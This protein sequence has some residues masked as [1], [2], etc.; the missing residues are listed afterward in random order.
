MTFK[1]SWDVN[2]VRDRIDVKMA[3]ER[4]KKEVRKRTKELVKR[5]LNDKHLMQ[6]VN[7]RV[8]PV[9]DYVMNVCKIGKRRFG[10][11]GQNNKR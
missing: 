1:S 4:V 2:K 8:I 3:M 9:A 5:N 7:T 10:L 6:A 11:P